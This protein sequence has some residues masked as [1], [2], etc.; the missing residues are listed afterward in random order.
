MLTLPFHTQEDT[1]LRQ[2][3]SMTMLTTTPGWQPLPSD[4]LI[5]YQ[6]AN[7]PSAS[8][9][10]ARALIHVLYDQILDPAFVEYPDTTSWHGGGE[11]RSHP[12]PDPM[13][14]RYSIL[15]NPTTGQI[16][17]LNNLIPY[18]EQVSVTVFN[19]LGMMV[20]SR[21]PIHP[22]DWF[23]LS[24]LGTGIYYLVLV[25]E[26]FGSQIIKVVKQ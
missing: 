16:Q 12:E 13:A 8:A 23:D 18:N 11:L 19:A 14:V 3:M 20:V 15:P 25:S 7:G 17:I 1:I 22:G 9:G 5:L 24:P 26:Q 4:S 2:M 6:I 10:H 21:Q